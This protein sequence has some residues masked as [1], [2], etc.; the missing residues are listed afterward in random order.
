MAQQKL[1]VGLGTMISNLTKRMGI[2]TCA[3]C[4]RRA[5]LLDAVVPNVTPWRRPKKT[6]RTQPEPGQGGP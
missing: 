3:S 1:P 2:S 6:K 4:A 5:A